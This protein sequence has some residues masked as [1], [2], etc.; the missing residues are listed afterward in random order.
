MSSPKTAV[1]KAPASKGTRRPKTA[2]RSARAAPAPEQAV[3]DAALAD[4]AR[5]LA[6]EIERGLADGRTLDP[7]ALQAL[8]AAVCKLYG[9]QV[10]VGRDIL[11]VK[12]R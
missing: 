4:T 10:E 3:G 7:Q 2:A 6:A 8:M 1:A 12:E 9:A 11:P 5:R